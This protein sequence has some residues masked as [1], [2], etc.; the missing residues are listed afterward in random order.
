MVLPDIVRSSLKRWISK[1]ACVYLNQKLAD[2]LEPETI[3]FILSSR[4]NMILIYDS[5]KAENMTLFQ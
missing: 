1:I 3:Q 2:I 4:V 5:Y